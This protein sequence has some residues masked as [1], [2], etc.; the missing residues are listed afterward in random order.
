MSGVDVSGADM[1]DIRPWVAS[2]AQSRVY[3]KDVV[4]RDTFR[5]EQFA[6]VTDY[7]E[8]GRAKQPGGL[9]GKVIGL[10][11]FDEITIDVV[12]CAV[13]LLG[14][15]PRVMVENF[16]WLHERYLEGDME[17][18]LRGVLDRHERGYGVRK[19]WYNK[20]EDWLIRG[21]GRMWWDDSGR[22]N[23]VTGEED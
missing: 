12:V 17:R 15:G 1:S 7:G 23:P 18:T 6:Y 11:A 9:R 4:I 22:L 13:R 19:R 5:G 21:R 16:I 20:I 2:M 14:G 3:A 10:F 8:V